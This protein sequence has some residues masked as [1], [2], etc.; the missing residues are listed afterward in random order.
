MGGTGYL[1]KGLTGTDEKLQ[2]GLRKIVEGRV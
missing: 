1:R 2:I